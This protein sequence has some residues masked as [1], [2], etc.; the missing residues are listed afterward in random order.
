MKYHSS[1][2]WNRLRILTRMCTVCGDVNK[3]LEPSYRYLG[4]LETDRVGG[5]AEVGCV[6]SDPR[7][8]RAPRPGHHLRSWVRRQVL[9]EDM[10]LRSYLMFICVHILLY[11]CSMQLHAGSF[12]LSQIS[13]RAFGLT[14]GLGHS[15]VHSQVYHR[16]ES[17]TGQRSECEGSGRMSDTG[18]YR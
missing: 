16:N 7:I 5:G 15:F 14:P 10:Y 13:I 12:P 9:C 11:Y 2:L 4:E 1:A 17:G 8:S 18:D 6:A 3:G